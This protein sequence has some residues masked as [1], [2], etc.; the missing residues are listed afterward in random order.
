MFSVTIMRYALLK[1]FLPIETDDHCQVPFRR[2]FRTVLSETYEIY[3]RILN[4]VDNRI[5]ASLGWDTPNWRV[6][7][8]CK[9]CCYV[10]R[11]LLLLF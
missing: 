11:V 3:V 10:V 7:N 5:N 1:F 8:A 4:I 2:Y 6:N 9:A